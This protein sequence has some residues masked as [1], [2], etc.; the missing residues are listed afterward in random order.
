MIKYDFLDSELENIISNG[1]VILDFYATWC[2]PC[3]MIA[4][5]LEAL[6][7]ENKDILVLEIDI[8]KHTMITRNYGIMSVPTLIF[9]KNG[10]EMN[11]LLGYRPKSDLLKIIEKFS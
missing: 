7:K 3:K 9:Y 1:I 8:D 4:P 10:K 6:V 2:G 11:K 5:E